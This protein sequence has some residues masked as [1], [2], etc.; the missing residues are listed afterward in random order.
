MAVVLSVR[1]EGL[2]NSEII[3]VTFHFVKHTKLNIPVRDV[4]QPVTEFWTNL[5]GDSGLE[6]RK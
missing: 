1:S 4:S 2:K 5:Q 6:K 3:I